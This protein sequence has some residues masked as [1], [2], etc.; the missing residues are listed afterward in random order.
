MDDIISRTIDA[1]YKAFCLTVDTSMY[2]RRERRITS[3]NVCYTKLL[4][5]E[6]HPLAMTKCAAR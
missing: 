2:S 5:E 6:L 1:G 4:R 3:Y